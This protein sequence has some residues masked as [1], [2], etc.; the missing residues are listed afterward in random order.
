M[1]EQIRI[2][3]GIKT[4]SHT[5]ICLD[6]M[7]GLK[8][9]G[10]I[11]DQIEYGGK[12][13]FKSVSSRFY[14]IL[15]HAIKLVARSY[16]FKPHF[17]YLNS[18]LEFLGSARDFLTISIFRMFYF[19]KVHFLIKSHGSDLQVLQTKNVFFKRIIFPFLKKQVSGWL[20]LSNEEVT[21]IASKKLLNVQNIF[22]AKNIVRCEKFQIDNTFRR[23][24][25]IPNDYKV[26]LFVGRIIE[27]KGIYYLIEAFA[28][29]QKKYKV[30]L[31]IVGDG[32]EFTKIKRKINDLNIK[33]GIKITG[34]VDEKEAA[35]FT[36][37]SDILILPTFFPEGFPMA[38][39][40][41]LAAG[42]SLV[43]TK[44]RAASDHLKEPENC[45]WV[46]P[47]SSLS[48][49][50]ALVRLLT[51][52][53]LMQTMQKNNKQKAHLF[54]KPFVSQEISNVLQTI[55]RKN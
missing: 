49:K 3:F 37:N 10:Y 9:M 51:D 52:E 29:V 1:K 11:C 31:F 44:I 38:L 24:F 32:T 33:E 43:T 8:E 4:K 28:E 12:V 5:E 26:L 19:K 20:F 13:N 35:Y 42:L 7:T 54:T 21:W 30:I 50:N 34:W 40:N 18:R 39:F 6:E 23:K 55:A 48:I 15:L 25:N 36:S 16:K 14:I 41:S 46:A 45:I 2:L 17:I 53:H 22:L 27:E 47:K